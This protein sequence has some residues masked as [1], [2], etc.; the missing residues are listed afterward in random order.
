VK[1]DEGET[2]CRDIE[3]DRHYLEEDGDAAGDSRLPLGKVLAGWGHTVAR[4]GRYGREKML[5]VGI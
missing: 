1:G 2:N 4:Q 5:M 3:V